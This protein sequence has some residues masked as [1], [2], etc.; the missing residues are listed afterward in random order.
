MKPTFFSTTA[1]VIGIIIVVN[2]LAYE[3]HVR[4]DLTEDRQYTLSDATHEILDNLEEPVTVKAYFSRNVP[5]EF[6]KARQ[7]FQDL[8]VEYANLSDNQVVYEFI[9]PNEKESYEQDAI[10]SGIRPVLINVREKDQVKQ[11]K[12]F[13]GATIQLGEKKEV[14]PFLRPGAAMEYALSTAIKKISIDN[15]PVVGFL[16]GHGEPSLSEM[17]QANDQL[18]VLYDTQEI[19]L[20]DSTT[21]AED[22]KTLVLIRPSDTIPTTQLNIL[23]GFL[24]RGGRLLVALNHVQADFRSMYGTVQNNTMKKWLEGKGIE[25]MDN[26]VVDANCGAVKVPQRLG[27]FTV[28]AN[29]S[30]PY[31]PVISTFA[32]H[33][34]T[35]GLESV[36]FEFASEVK[37]TGDSTEKF[38]PLA[39][40]SEQSNTMPAPQFIDINKEWTESDFPRKN[41]PVAAAIVGNPMKMV[42][43]SDGDFPVNG[44]AD[45]Q[46]Q[47]QP[48]NVSFLSNAI[49]WLSD[50]TGLIAL[51]TKGV[52]SRPIR[53]LEETTK[54]ILKYTNFLLPILLVIGYG[55]F[56]SQRNRMI[57]LRRMSETYESLP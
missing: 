19:K 30:F 12:A 20:T 15:K 44:P 40:S 5:P 48:D 46:R 32:D 55:I 6:G 26:F 27:I 50:D 29:V 11:Q 18:S 34:I 8:L 43:I 36:M 41:I 24:K 54:T 35:T 9:N 33:P 47:L 57:R 42:V 53:E 37:F 1:L 22:I 39:F 23:D 2:L 56:R 13:L 16:T 51:R 17:K 7:D 25:L 52:V 49:D 10:N 45:Q 3:Y 4:L 28:E 14:I 21:I 38:Y 31:V